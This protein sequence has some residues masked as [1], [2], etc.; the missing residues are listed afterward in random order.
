MHHL[1]CQLQDSIDNV[2]IQHQT[3]QTDSN[4][5]SLQNQEAF[6]RCSTMFLEFEFIVKVK[7][8]AVMVFTHDPNET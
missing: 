3:N 5:P 7:K 4:I 8:E 6:L 1:A 2:S